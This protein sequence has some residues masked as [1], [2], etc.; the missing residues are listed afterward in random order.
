MRART[1][2]LLLSFA[3]AGCAVAPSDD[4]MTGEEGDLGTAQSE[5]QAA[6]GWKQFAI[7]QDGSRASKA[8]G[9]I[10][11]PM[12]EA[13][14]QPATIPSSLG[15]L[16]VRGTCGVT[17]ISPHYAITAAHCVEATH[18]PD[19]ANTTLIV[20]QF[21]VTGANLL[22]LHT[23]ALIKGTYPNYEPLSTPMNNVAGYL[24]TGLSCKVV[25]RCASA[26]IPDSPAF[27]CDFPGDVAMLHCGNRASNGSWLPVASTDPLSGPVEMY[28]FHELLSPIPLTQPL[29]GAPL[30]EF[31]RF[32][33]YTFLNGGSSDKLR[34]RKNNWHY[35]A[36]RTNSLLPLKS[37][38]F[39]DGSPRKRLF[40]STRTDLFGCHGTSGS[41]VLQ[42]NATGDLELLGPVSTAAQRWGLQRICDDPN[43]LTPGVEGLS[44]TSNSVTNQMHSK[45]SRL[46]TLDR[47]PLVI[48]PWPPIRSLAS[49]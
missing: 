40:N 8:T 42:R 13:N 4:P 32:S 17:F 34:A 11:V 37:V 12:R 5:V 14:G 2:G 35:V 36:A 3:L 15:A 43:A 1:L 33:H 39:Q 44:Y 22:S 29:A 25:S 48:D 18:V 38:P 23:A 46:I 19:P 26:L 10:E 20:R 27:N 16:P 6:E 47:N 28:W 41:G 45:Y 9:A 21:D 49:P 7:A 30:V 24:T 31:D